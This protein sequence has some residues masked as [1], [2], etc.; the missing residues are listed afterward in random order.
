MRAR[1]N[2]YN[3]LIGVLIVIVLT[4]GGIVALVYVQVSRELLAQ[5]KMSVENRVVSLQNSVVNSLENVSVS[6]RSLV[7][8]AAGRQADR[9][10]VERMLANF[11]LSNAYVRK[12]FLF[13]P[14]AP[15]FE[16][17]GTD[18][19]ALDQDLDILEF[20]ATGQP[21]ITGSIFNDAQGWFVGPAVRDAMGLSTHLPI[22]VYEF[23]V[24]GETAA[25]FLL[26]DLS[27]LLFSLGDSLYLSVE[28][29]TVPISIAVYDDAG[30]L[31]ETTLNNPL[32][33]EQPIAQIRGL[34]LGLPTPPDTGPGTIETTVRDDRTGLWL[35]G[36]VSESPI[37]ERASRISAQILL[38]GALSLGVILA[39]GILLLKTVERLQTAERQRADIRIRSLQATMN[40][41]FLFNSLDTIVGLAS[42][43]NHDGL[44]STLRALSLQLHGAV[45]DADDSILVSREIEYLESYL[46]IQRYRYADTF[47][48]RLHVPSEARAVRIPRFCI[49]PLLENCFAHAIPHVTGR[50]SIDLS[51]T[52]TDDSLVVTVS[53]NGPGC[54]DERW[55]EVSSGLSEMDESNARGVGLYGVHQHLVLAYGERYGIER[56][57]TV[58]GFTV[59][60]SLPVV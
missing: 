35:S 56:I 37:V 47:D 23:P 44:M 59:K 41:H 16:A 14:G 26:L 49:Q 39:L 50:L 53:D 27:E 38:I 20:T 52:I 12:A 11:M 36:S 15:P 43:K 46:V 51:T 9:R 3:V 29:G 48:F 42:G 4:V 6:M 58:S 33:S 2:V 28:S 18:V 45:R 60:L 57:P 7:R 40:P 10:A 21:Q 17:P 30:R 22:V 32:V 55:E 5:A 24:N 25:G 13:Y 1:K 54:S 31:L 19:R 8:A 34:A